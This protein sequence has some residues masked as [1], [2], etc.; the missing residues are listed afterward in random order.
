MLFKRLFGSDPAQQWPDVRDDEPVT[1][2]LARLT[3]CGIRLREPA[4]ALRSIGRPANSKPHKQ[5]I[6]IYPTLGLE[7]EHND[8]MY[9]R[10]FGLVIVETGFDHVGDCRPL[11]ITPSGPRLTIGPQTTAAELLQHLPHP[12]ETVIANDDEGDTVTTVKLRQCTL[13]IEASPLGTVRRINLDA[14]DQ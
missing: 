3:L 12:L 8:E 4:D 6:F 13:E 9:I 10:H 11:I 14:S 2:D 1:L 7:I 5:G